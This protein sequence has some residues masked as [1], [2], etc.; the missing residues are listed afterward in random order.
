MGYNGLDW[1][2][3]SLQLIDPG[4]GKSTLAASAGKG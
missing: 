3:F 1:I 4:S 2:F